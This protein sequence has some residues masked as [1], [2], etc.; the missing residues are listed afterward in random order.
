[1]SIGSVPSTRV[2]DQYVS[3][4][5]LTQLEAD[6]K[7]LTNL[8]EQISTGN[9]LLLPS[10]NPNEAMQGSRPRACSSRRARPRPT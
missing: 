1:M 2:S 7:A 10:D 9:Q 3:M 4:Q 6:Q 5:L 8:Q